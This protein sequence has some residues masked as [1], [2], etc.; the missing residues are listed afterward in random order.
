MID[1]ADVALLRAGAVARH[2]FVDLFL[3]AGR[4]RLW[5]GVGTSPEF[6]GGFYAGV[7]T[8]AN[9]DFGADELSRQNQDFSISI[10][11]S[12]VDENGVAQAIDGF[13]DIVDQSLTNVALAGREV[14]VHELILDVGRSRVLLNPAIAASGFIDTM[15]VTEDEQ[16]FQ[17]ITMN[18][19]DS[20]SI[21]VLNSV[22]YHGPASHQM[23][24]PGSTF[25]AQAPRLR[26]ENVVWG[27]DSAR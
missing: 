22:R 26:E 5:D 9:I 1:P 15:P 4:A 25:L 16:G 21:G 17:S 18:L 6:D 20:T 2:L 7:G 10:S 23:I 24:N 3:E 14:R 8:I 19:K 13:S 27:V 12:F 11:G